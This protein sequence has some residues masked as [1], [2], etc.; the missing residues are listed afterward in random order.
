M[1]D[2]KR[3]RLN[4]LEIANRLGSQINPQLPLLD[5]TEICKT[6]NDVVEDDLSDEFDDESI[7]VSHTIH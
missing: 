6:K 3:I 4:S 5:E 1:I 7:E 2:Y